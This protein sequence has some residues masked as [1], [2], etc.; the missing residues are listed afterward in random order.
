LIDRKFLVTPESNEEGFEKRLAE[1]PKVSSSLIYVW[2]YYCSK[3]RI[4]ISDPI[5]H[6]QDLKEIE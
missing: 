6:E 5:V 4:L 2:A 3:N 1:S